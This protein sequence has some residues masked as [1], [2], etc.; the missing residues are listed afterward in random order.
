MALPHKI[1]KQVLLNTGLDP[2][3]H[4]GR[5]FMRDLLFLGRLC[6]EE[7]ARTFLS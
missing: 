4:F 7:C 6:P 1:A 2:A 5:K 3:F